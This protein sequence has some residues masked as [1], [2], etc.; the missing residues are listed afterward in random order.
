MTSSTTDVISNYAPIGI[1]EESPT[2]EAIL[3]AVDSKLDNKLA[4]LEE[5]E[6]IRD[7]ILK[8][9]RTAKAPEKRERI[10]EALDRFIEALED[11]ASITKNSYIR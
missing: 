6:A 3:E 5:L 7:R 8:N 9:W 1:R 2:V 11:D 10:K 4:E